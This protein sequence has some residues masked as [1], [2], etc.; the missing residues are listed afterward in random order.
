MRRNFLVLEEGSLDGGEGL[1]VQDEETGVCERKRIVCPN[2]WWAQRTRA[3]LV[4][5]GFR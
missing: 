4:W 2:K 3:L 5:T 1:C